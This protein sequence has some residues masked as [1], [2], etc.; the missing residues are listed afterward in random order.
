[1]QMPFAYALGDESGQVGFKFARGSTEFFVFSLLLTR[2]LAALEDYTAFFRSRIGLRAGAELKFHSTPDRI[3]Q[4]FLDGLVSQDIAVRAVYVRKTLLPSA[5]ATLKSWD[6]YAYFVSY[7]LD[8]LPVGELKATKLILDEFGP[9]ELTM[10]ALRTRLDALWPD[11][12]RFLIERIRFRS[13][14]KQ[15]GLQ[16]ADMISGAVYRWLTEEDRRFLEIMGSKTLIW[17]YRSTNNLPT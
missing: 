3:R 16:A 10:R 7:L 8:R 13:S 14:E 9:H 11:S 12:R 5:F 2:D 1:M 4:E 6:F 17:E 15:G